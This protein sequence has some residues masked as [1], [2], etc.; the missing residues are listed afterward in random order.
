MTGIVLTSC[1]IANPTS[2]PRRAPNLINTA[3]NSIPIV[4]SVVLSVGLLTF[5]V[6]TLLG[7]SYYG[8]KP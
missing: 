6:S 4:G 7:W 1:I 5:T 8:E 3:F 2:T